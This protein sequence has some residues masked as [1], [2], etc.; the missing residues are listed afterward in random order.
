MEGSHRKVVRLED[1][2]RRAGVTS[3]TVS[4]ALAGTKG[5]SSST[6]E[7][8]LKIANEMGYIPN[9]QAAGLRAKRSYILGFLV[10]DIKNPFYANIAAG[11]ESAAKDRGFR[12][13]L[14]VTE[15]D[16]AD[17]ARH[18]QMLLEHHV[19]GLIL[20]PVSRNQEGSYQNIDLLRAF[21]Q[22]GTPVICV[23]DSVKDFPSGRI[24]TAVYHGTRMLMDHLIELGHREIAYFS[25]PFQRIQKYGRHTAYYD[26]LREAGIPERPELIVETGLTPIEAYRKTAWALDS[27]LRFTAAMYANDYMAF[28]GMRA[29][30]ERGI[31]VPAEV[32]VCG[33]DD[34][35]W[36]Q[37]CEVPL[38][39]A[40]FP[41]R[42]IGEMAV[43]ELVDCLSDPARRSDFSEPFC[44]VA[45]RPTLIVR[46]STG[47]APTGLPAGSAAAG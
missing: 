34:V 36:A 16:P 38:T 5:V 45:V 40:R 10:P 15:D 44:D 20:A 6:R 11:F 43:R 27:G 31:R 33:F 13:M 24:T 25:Q 3:A 9:R 12:L 29:L 18:L 47:P 7:R 1:I 32:S 22:R 17:E 35:E 19:D 46:Q 26:A 8:I 28:G 41:I 37:F 30:R 2:A 21:H 4:Y 39:T 14:C 42:Q 23:V